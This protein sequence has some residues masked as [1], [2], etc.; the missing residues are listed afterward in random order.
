MVQLQPTC[1]LLL[2]PALTR[3]LDLLI[4]HRLHR[5]WP[6]FAGCGAA[7][8]N[9]YCPDPLPSPTA[10]P[11]PCDHTQVAP[12]LAHFCGVWCSTLRSVR[13][14]FE[15]EHAFL[16]LCAVV[17]LN[18]EPAVAAFPQVAG[19]VASWR[20]VTTAALSAEM[21]QLLQVGRGEGTW[22]WG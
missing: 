12:H 6:T 10:P 21:L 15:K 19:A 11:R 7:P 3:C 20:Q 14:D 9:C 22:E 16:G 2:L 8:T 13:D 4:P 5:T 18:P 17:R 1:S